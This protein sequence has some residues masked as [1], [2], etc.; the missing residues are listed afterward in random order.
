MYRRILVPIDGSDPAS[1]GLSEAIR[2]AKGWGATLRLLHA[3]CAELPAALS[4][5][6]RMAHALR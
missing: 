3:V 6:V 5:A 4:T 2:L 1:H